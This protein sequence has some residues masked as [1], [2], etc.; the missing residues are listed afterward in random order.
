MK[1]SNMFNH[2]RRPYYNYR[3]SEMPQNSEASDVHTIEKNR[4]LELLK[5][6]RRRQAE[7]KGESEEEDKPA[8][9]GS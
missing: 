5:N 6:L 3:S 8:S 4:F 7:A 2:P 1:E 9:T